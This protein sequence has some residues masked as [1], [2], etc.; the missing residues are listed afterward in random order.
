[1]RRAVV[2]HGRIREIGPTVAAVEPLEE[3]HEVRSVRPFDGRAIRGRARGGRDDA[4]TRDR[5]LGIDA[6]DVQD[7]LGLEV[8]RRRILAEVRELDDARVRPP[9]TRNV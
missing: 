4:G 2:A 6:R 3:P 1:M 9:S 8:E 5:Q 7:R